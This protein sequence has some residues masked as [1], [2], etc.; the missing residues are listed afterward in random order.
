MTL[1]GGYELKDIVEAERER[2]MLRV[3]VLG[4]YTLKAFASFYALPAGQAEEEAVRWQS[5]RLFERKKNLSIPLGVGTMLLNGAHLAYLVRQVPDETLAGVLEA[6]AL[7]TEEAADLLRAI[8]R[9]LGELHGKGYVHGCI[10]PEEILAVGDDIELSTDCLRRVNGEPIVEPK[11]AKYL[12]PE[13]ST[14]NVTIASDVWCIGATIF[15]SLSQ[16]RYEPGLFAEAEA[17]KHPFGTLLSSALDPDPEKRCRVS[18]IEPIL[19]S[20]AP[21]PKPKPVVPLMPAPESKAVP[22]MPAPLP[23]TAKPTL[24][25]SLAAGNGS[26]APAEELVTATASP[27]AAPA[28]PSHPVTPSL[29]DAVNEK[30]PI[31]EP[32]PVAPEVLVMPT[33]K[34]SNTESE[35]STASTASSGVPASVG[36]P[37]DRSTFSHA[38]ARPS[39]SSPEPPSPR[40]G[41]RSDAR[42]IEEDLDTTASSRRRGWIYAIAAFVLVFLMLLFIRSYSRSTKRSAVSAAQTSAATATAPPKAQPG[43]AW[44]TQT[45]TPDNK[46]AATRPERA[47]PSSGVT[48]AAKDTGSDLQSRTIWRV[49]LY[50]YRKQQDAERKAHEVASRRPDLQPEVFTPAGAGG[51]FL[52]VAGGRMS[53]EAA[54]RLRQ[55]AL[56]EGMPRDS[57]IQNYSK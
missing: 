13:S 9:G 11:P 54:G 3:R 42:R 55:R 12:A 19:R 6:R 30:A 53:R 38:S 43:A 46:S 10:S 41:L 20:K 1:E 44:P 14:H 50:T 4:D 51:P 52:V 31:E 21:P 24:P 16:K 7:Q 18:E 57:Y 28:V 29:F 2:A 8:A 56:R 48:A 15:E 17:I 23:E 39:V 26:A 45:L 49:V 5:L 40:F 35:K 34:L 47:G 37:S 33:A 25:A 22:P 27:A 36:R 32:K